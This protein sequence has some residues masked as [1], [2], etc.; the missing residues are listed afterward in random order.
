MQDYDA[1]MTEAD[2]AE[3]D[4]REEATAVRRLEWLARERETAWVAYEEQK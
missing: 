1:A 3:R 2:L 4:A